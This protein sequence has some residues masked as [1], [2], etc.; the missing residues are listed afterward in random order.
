MTHTAEWDW[1]GLLTR[2]SRAVLERPELAGSLPGDVRE[3]GWLGYPGATE[4]QLRSAEARLAIP[5]PP[6]YRAF[7]AASNGFRAPGAFVDVVWPA[8]EIGWYAA[9]HQDLIDGWMEGHRLFAGLATPSVRDAEYFVYGEHQDP[10]RL[11]PEYLQ[12]ALQ[13]SPFG[14]AAVYLLNPK[15]VTPEG[16]WEAWMHASWLPGAARYRSFWELMVEEFESFVE[17]E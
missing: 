16:E 2:W 12:T 5:L 7:L 11:R 8:E 15:A 6:S 1:N 10:A 17:S 3:T 9:R 4:E 14:D 13:V